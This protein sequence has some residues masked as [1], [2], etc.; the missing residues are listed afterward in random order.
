[1]I[2][3]VP[4]SVRIIESEVGRAGDAAVKQIARIGVVADKAAPQR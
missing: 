3:Y 1:M 4:C 2:F